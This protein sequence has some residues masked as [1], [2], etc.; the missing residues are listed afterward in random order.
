MFI[1]VAQRSRGLPLLEVIVEWETVAVYILFKILTRATG[2]FICLAT[3]YIRSN[4]PPQISKTLISCFC[5]STNH[6]TLNRVFCAQSASI[7]SNARAT[8]N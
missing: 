6:L 2:L 5:T 3:E 1:Q 7:L 4:L 8:I